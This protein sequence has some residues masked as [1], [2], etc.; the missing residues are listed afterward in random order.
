MGNVSVFGENICMGGAMG[1]GGGEVFG[2]K[3]HR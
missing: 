2:G 3:V 1:G